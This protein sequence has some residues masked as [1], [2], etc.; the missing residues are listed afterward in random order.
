VTAVADTPAAA[1]RARARE[2]GAR[3]QGGWLDR[4]LTYYYLVVGSASLLVALGLI[5]VLSASSVQSYASSGSS[6]SIVAKQAMWVAIGLPIMV[7]AARMPVRFYR[8]LGYPLMIISIVGLMAVLVPH[9]GVTVNGARRWIDLPA[10]IQIQ[11]SEPAKLALV[12]WGADLL[13]RKEKLLDDWRHLVMPLVPVSLLLGGLL[14]LEPDM[15]TTIVLMTV[16]LALL[17]VVGAPARIFGFTFGGLGGALGVLAVAEPYRLARLTSFT[18]PFADPLGAGYQAVQ[19]IYA[20]AS[21]GWWGLGLGASREKWAYLPNQY[22]D[23]I[24]AI[25]GEEL[26][27]IGAFVVLLL[28]GLL[29]YGGLR[30]ARRATD[31]FSQLAAAAVTAWLLSQAIVNIGYVVGVLPVTGI[32]LPMVSFGGSAMVPTLFAIGMLASFARAEPGAAEALA[33]RPGLLRRRSRR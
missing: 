29:G 25:I 3:A 12:L 10:G 5:M 14:M 4:P 33:A 17:W 8:A 6:F 21:G 20:L 1:R 31:R 19:G 2:A 28:F 24:F 15:G 26:G 18:N 30:I 7:F 27:L 13:A 9:I 16:M 11:P 22:T 32:P 23:Y